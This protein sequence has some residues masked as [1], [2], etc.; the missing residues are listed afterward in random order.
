MLPNNLVI[1][2][3]Q[4]LTRLVW[5]EIANSSEHIMSR[6]FILVGL[7]LI[8]FNLKAFNLFEIPNKF[9]CFSEN[10]TTLRCAD[11]YN[12]RFISVNHGGKSYI[13]YGQN[14][15]LVNSKDNLSIVASIGLNK[16]ELLILKDTLN[17]DGFKANL[18]INHKLI[19]LDCV[20]YH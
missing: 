2:W 4:I 8:C 15:G 6:I 3:N 7:F 17:Q 9:L 1:F 20:E 14:T 5:R 16:L 10:I 13:F 18:S 19:A 12:N 11:L